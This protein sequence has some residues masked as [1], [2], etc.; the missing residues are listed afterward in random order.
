ME[1]KTLNKLLLL[2][3][4]AIAMA[5]L[6]ASVVIYLRALY[7]P[8]GFT[9]PIKQMPINMAVIEL[10]REAST[11]VMLLAVAFLAERSA[12]GRFICFMFL[13]GI[14]DI[15]YYVW[16]R[17]TIG[18]PS[19]LLT[20]DLLFLIPVIWTGPV[21]APVL[22]S[23]L[24]ITT[25]LIYYKYEDASERMTIRAY[26]WLMIIGAAFVIFLA[27]AYNHTV[28]FRGGRPQHFPWEIFALGMVLGILVVVRL[29]RRLAFYIT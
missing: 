15:F 13:F 11:I 16:L 27:F 19:S 25:S 7:Y 10:V 12:R 14:W 20:W 23:I 24:M 4:F 5:Y 6:E 8:E 22:V 3:T 28:T 21:I 1:R 18:W 29:R 2:S 26:E 17:A 9:F